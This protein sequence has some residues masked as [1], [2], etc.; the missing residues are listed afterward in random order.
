MLIAYSFHKSIFYI[1]C[2]R[3]CHPRVT[4]NVMYPYL[5]NSI[6]TAGELISQQKSPMCCYTGYR[7]KSALFLCTLQK[8][9]LLKESAGVTHTEDDVIWRQIVGSFVTFT[10]Y[11]PIEFGVNLR[12][13]RTGIYYCSWELDVPVSVI[14][15]ELQYVGR[16]YCI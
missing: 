4:R 5:D 13:R 3:K 2:M 9:K 12:L 14:V 8:R 15:H 10:Q 7:L 16:L 11:M 1:R 6:L